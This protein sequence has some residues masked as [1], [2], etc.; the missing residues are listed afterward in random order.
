MFQ[1]KSNLLL[2]FIP[3][4]FMACNNDNEDITDTV[5]KNGSIETS[6]KIDHLDSARDV[7]ITSH[8]V[9]VKQQEYKT[10]E[11]RD[12]LPALGVENTEA[13]NEEG[14]TKRVSVP[15]DYEIFITVK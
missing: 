9:W 13:E 6:V 3:L 4:A 15:K 7:L 10:I 12:T 8:K 2:L 1:I 14:D 5:N 11:Y